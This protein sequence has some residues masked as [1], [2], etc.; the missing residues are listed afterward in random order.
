MEK[1]IPMLKNNCLMPGS[2][3]LQEF[4]M[5]VQTAMKNSFIR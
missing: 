1:S 5:L 2:Q 3:P 4:E